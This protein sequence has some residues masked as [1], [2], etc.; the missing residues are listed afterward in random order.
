MK[1]FR[2]ELISGDEVARIEVGLGL[3]NRAHR[4]CVGQDCQGLFESFEVVR[5]DDHRSGPAIARE[6]DAI[7]LTFHSV[8][9]LR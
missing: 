4:L 2:P 3:S 5:A 1:I 9:D 8:H 6:Y 7:M